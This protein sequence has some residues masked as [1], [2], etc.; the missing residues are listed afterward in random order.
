VKDSVIGVRGE[1]ICPGGRVGKVIF[2]F[3]PWF[4][5]GLIDCLER[6][7]SRYDLVLE[8]R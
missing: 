1:L 7:G 4:L 3:C 2:G 5:V 8:A 6:A